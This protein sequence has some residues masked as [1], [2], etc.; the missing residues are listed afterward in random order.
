L[1]I[2]DLKD[3]KLLSTLARVAGIG[4]LVAVVMVLSGCGE[5]AV[6]PSAFRPAGPAAARINF[7]WWVLLGLGAGV[8]VVVMGLLAVGL[9]RRREPIVAPHEASLW[10]RYGNSL[11]LIGGAIIPALILVVVFGF[12][13]NT[14]AALTRSDNRADALLIEV[15]GHQWWWEVHYPHQQFRTANEIYI[16]AGQP[17]QLRLSAADVIHSFWAPELHGK[18][19]LLPGRTNTLWLEATEPGEFWGVCAEFCGT[20]HAKMLF[21]IVALPEVEFADW[22]AAQQAPAAT[23]TDAQAREG[24]AIFLAV[25]CSDCHRIRG[26]TAEGEIATGTAG[27]DL[28]HFASRLTLGAGAAPNQRGH[29]AGWVVNPHGLKPGN[30]MPATTLSGAELTALLAYLE[31]LE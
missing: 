29:L 27:P 7:L 13:F 5:T 24:Q 14:L 28:T 18:L 1:E 17:V 15:I 3:R 30:L 19:D 22:L 11:V 8:Y 4:L 20:Q 23:P 6:T 10:Q 31:S 2:G 12:T 26:L 16:P 9:W 25:G 21:V